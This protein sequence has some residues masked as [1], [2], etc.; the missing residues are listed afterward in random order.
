M[1]PLNGGRQTGSVRFQIVAAEPRPRM[2]GPVFLISFM[3]RSLT[4][5]EP[6]TDGLVAQLH[7]NGTQER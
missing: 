2:Q 7:P 5:S 3:E 4:I 6:K 1:G